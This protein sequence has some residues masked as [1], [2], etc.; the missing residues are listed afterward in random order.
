MKHPFFEGID[1][2]SDLTKYEVEDMLNEQT[3]MT[4]LS[5]SPSGIIL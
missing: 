1:F 2:N 4:R 5:V 3:P